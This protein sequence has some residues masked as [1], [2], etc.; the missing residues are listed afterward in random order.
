VV[1]RAPERAGPLIHE[2]ERAGAEVLKLPTM[3]SA[4]PVNCGPMNDVLHQIETFDA[5]LFVSASAV[6][7][8]F[9]QSTIL[10]KREQLR[11]FP[12]RLIAAVGPVTAQSAVDHGIRI[13][14]VA[15][16]GTGESLVMELGAA[17]SGHKVFLPRS[18]RGDHRL[19]DAL[20]EAGALV[21]E[22]VAYSTPAPEPLDPELV[23]RIR[24]AEV[25][26]ITFT[27]PSAFLNLFDWIDSATL[28][29]L[30]SRVR[31]AAIGPTTAKCIRKAGSQV[32]I[33][34]NE[35]SVQGLTYAIVEYYQ[36]Q[37]PNVKGATS[38]PK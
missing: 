4:A 34:A 24:R 32:E 22:V 27:S 1:T 9:K 21:T 28:A 20:R 36:Q 31:F 15:K 14:F 16:G 19:A 12:G 25:D 11:N 29:R 17:L 7:S 8:T 10:N 35:P 2:L 30:S 33:E 18:D 38:H 23:E 37:E 5:I 13:D 3:G 26:V 6:R